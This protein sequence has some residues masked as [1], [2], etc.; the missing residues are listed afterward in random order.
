[1]KKNLEIIGFENKATKSEPPKVYTRFKT[2]E[3]W[4]SCFD[5]TVAKQVKA[6][7]G[8]VCC[9]EMT[10]KDGTNFKGEPMVYKNIIKCYGTAEQGIMGGKMVDG[11]EHV[12]TDDHSNFQEDTYDP[13][14]EVVKIGA[15]NT[16][17]SQ[18]KGFQQGKSTAQAAMYTSYA[19]DI[20]CT[21]L[22]RAGNQEIDQVKAMDVAIKLVKQAREAFE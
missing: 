16:T 2:S 14:P 13:K 17:Q 11:T 10:E 18:N 22:E 4:M 21:E 3:G 19:K 20:F 1:M 9:V 5:E 7:Q 6:Y 8:G 15:Q 12:K